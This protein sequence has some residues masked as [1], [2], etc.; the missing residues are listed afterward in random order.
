MK[1]ILILSVLVLAVA[2]FV[3]ADHTNFTNI[4][5]TGTTDSD[6]LR[7]ATV[8]LPGNLKV[9]GTAN[10]TGAFSQSGAIT[11]GSNITADGYITATGYGSFTGGIRT[12][13]VIKLG[14]GAYFK[15][16][17][18]SL[19][20]QFVNKSGT[21]I[22]RY[23]PVEMDSSAQNIV[24]EVKVDGGP[25]TLTEALEINSDGGYWRV[26]ASAFS[27]ADACSLVLNGTGGD[28][29]GTME[30]VCETL[31]LTA[32]ET[33]YCSAT[34]IWT[35]LDTLESFET[36]TN[37]SVVVYAYPLWSIITAA[38]N[39]TMLMGVTVDS[40][41]DNDSGYVCVYGPALVHTNGA[42]APGINLQATGSATADP[43]SSVTVGASL[44]HAIEASS[45]EDTTW[46]FIDHK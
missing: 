3:F 21:L 5:T 30:T 13:S 1:K 38:S 32:N 15:N 22:N 18:P 46:C 7:G 45:G 28:I 14:T 4:I 16:A 23:T 8:V 44:G 29:G 11:G 24:A 12:D 25:D 19:W 36:E 9:L 35:D 10:I 26:V 43:V 42:C 40:I 31:A 37:D 20:V 41:A 17:Y 33:F 2:V 27:I 34:Q 39:G 6:S